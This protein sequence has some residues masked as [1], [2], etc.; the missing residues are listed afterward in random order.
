MS[1]LPLT[2]LWFC[3][4][5]TLID[6]THW[7]VQDGGGGRGWNCPKKCQNSLDLNHLIQLFGK[8]VGFNPKLPPTTATHGQVISHCMVSCMNSLKPG[9]WNV[10]I[11]L[12]CD[13]CFQFQFME[14]QYTIPRAGDLNAN[15]ELRTEI[16]RMA[17][18]LAQIHEK[19]KIHLVEDMQGGYALPKDIHSNMVSSKKLQSLPVK[20]HDIS[21]TCVCVCV[22]GGCTYT[23]C[24]VSVLSLH[25]FL[26]FEVEHKVT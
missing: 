2:L 6:I 23:C 4:K 17:H 26:H 11:N 19:V 20:C 16:A 1:F 12:C 22:G 13:F 14:G 21:W 7:H 3:W 5:L 18:D 24:N 10:K 9:L 8:R 25:K 15:C